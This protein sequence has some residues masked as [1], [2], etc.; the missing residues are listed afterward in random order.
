MRWFHLLWYIIS[1]SIASYIA[2]NGVRVVDCSLTRRS[3]N[4]ELHVLNFF[5]NSLHEFQNEID[6]LLLLVL[7]Q[8]FLCDKE[9]EV[10]FGF[11]WLSPHNLELIGSQSEETLQHICKQRFNFILLNAERNTATV[12]RGLDQA[13]LE[14]ITADS[15]F[16]HQQLFAVT[17]LDLGVGLSLDF[18]RRH[19]SQTETC[20]KCVSD[21]L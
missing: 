1:F 7:C 4:G 3:N 16:A 15:D 19:E 10:V 5:I 2:C 9:A 14:L 6:E 12:H 21:R 20:I 8:V 17:K 11:C 13:R 18:L